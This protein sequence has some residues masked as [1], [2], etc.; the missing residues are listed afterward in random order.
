[1]DPESQAVLLPDPP[2]TPTLEQTSFEPVTSFESFVPVWLRDLEPSH[3]SLETTG[4]TQHLKQ[5]ELWSTNLIQKESI[6]AKLHSIGA[7]DIARPLKECH[8]RQSFAQCGGCNTIKTFWNRCE[9]F[10]CPVCAP[11]LTRDRVE[12]ITWWVTQLDQPK[13]LVLTVQNTNHLTQAYVNWFKAAWTKLRRRKIARG[14]AGGIYRLEITYGEKGWHL[15]LHALVNAKWIDK[16][17]VARQWAELVGQ[18]FAIVWVGDARE[19]D[20]LKEV[21][22]YAV[23]GSDLAKWTPLQIATF[24]NAFQGVRT[25]GVFGDLYGLRTKYAD[26]I[27]TLRSD[28]RKCKCGCQQ[29]HVYSQD[30]WEWRQTTYAPIVRAMPPPIP[31]LDLHWQ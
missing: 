4:V 18:D 1:V 8:T 27:K 25:F 12:S 24:V 3:V 28:R 23:K 19:R 17:E 30:E 20:Y 15:H 21:T 31:Q 26:W 29:W 5:S 9:V 16:Q 14:W 6:V 22:K 11:A 2:K 7:D 10:Y 13:H